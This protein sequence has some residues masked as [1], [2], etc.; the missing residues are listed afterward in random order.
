MAYVAESENSAPSGDS[1]S[2]P[3]EPPHGYAVESG[4]SDPTSGSDS[5]FSEAPELHI[6]RPHDWE[7]RHIADSMVTHYL[8]DVYNSLEDV[9]DAA[10]SL[11]WAQ[12]YRSS[13]GLDLSSLFW[14]TQSKHHQLRVRLCE[15]PNDL[16]FSNLVEHFLCAKCGTW[17]P[18]R[19]FEQHL[20]LGELSLLSV[21][22]SAVSH[23]VPD[24]SY[25]CR[26][27]FRNHERRAE[28]NHWF[29]HHLLK[30]DWPS[31]CHKCHCM[32]MHSA[33]PLHSQSPNFC[34]H[35]RQAC[36]IMPGFLTI[37]RF[38]YYPGHPL[39]YLYYV[40]IWPVTALAT[41]R[42]W[43]SVAKTM[44]YVNYHRAIAL[45][46]FLRSDVPVFRCVLSFLCSKPMPLLDQYSVLLDSMLDLILCGKFRSAKR[47]ICL[48]AR[49][50]RRIQLSDRFNLSYF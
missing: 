6:R 5:G 8:E 30:P 33:L 45:S 27:A 21:A 16:D 14:S 10:G 50:S 23:M 2:G 32:I 3:S 49:S 39:A 4:D 13:L 29:V 44:L 46:I 42:L 35:A 26:L 43:E 1:D 38:V 19:F 15:P 40:G 28:K 34:R 31:F 41:V 17:V 7:P 47:L 22:S 36:A 20:P 25:H 11:A 18:D 24:S 12:D 37:G 48:F 9:P